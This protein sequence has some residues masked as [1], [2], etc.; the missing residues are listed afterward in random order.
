MPFFFFFNIVFLVFFQQNSR[1]LLHIKPCL[2]LSQG[3]VFLLGWI[4]WK[5]TLRDDAA[6]PFAVPK[7]GIGG[8]V[9]WRYRVQA[10]WGKRDSG[11]GRVSLAVIYKGP[12]TT[13]P[14]TIHTH[15]VTARS[16]D[17]S[18]GYPEL[19][20]QNGKSHLSLQRR[21]QPGKDSKG[22]VSRSR[23]TDGRMPETESPSSLLGH[24]SKVSVTLQWA[25][26]KLP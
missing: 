19:Q 4:R 2:I 6:G 12:P 26:I 10:P 8:R 14:S 1:F 18:P 13:D 25:L 21:S 11:G 15:G 5:F 23:W 24:V 17:P 7:M 20:R 3:N 22:L 16:Q 9:V